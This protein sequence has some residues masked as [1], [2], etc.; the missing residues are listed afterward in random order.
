MA[1]A[2]PT[3]PDIYSAWLEGYSG[4]G[5]P[6]FPI[7]E[8]VR[9]DAVDD[10]GKSTGY[11]QC[12]GLWRLDWVER[13][14]LMNLRIKHFRC[15]R[16]DGHFETVYVEQATRGR[17]QLLDLL[18]EAKDSLEDTAIAL[19]MATVFMST[20][21]GRYSFHGRDW[22]KAAWMLSDG[23][24]AH[25]GYGPRAVWHFSCTNLFPQIEADFVGPAAKE[26]PLALAKAYGAYHRELLREQVPYAKLIGMGGPTQDI[27]DAA[28]AQREAERIARE[29]ILQRKA[30]EQA[31]QE[32]KAQD[33]AQARSTAL[34]RL[35][36]INMPPPVQSNL[37]TM[38]KEDL[39][40]AVW[41]MTTQ[42][43]AGLL[44]CSDVAIHKR[45]RRL[46]IKT[47]PRGFWQRVAAGQIPHPQ[48]IE[49]ETDVR[50]KLS[51]RR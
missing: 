1:E 21:L 41:S 7:F 18:L 23:L 30:L 37:A 33:I 17:S 6:I 20:N 3:W 15:L 8:E 47:P 12:H 25:L 38:S 26:N 48:G 28:N 40:K 4:D 43:L 27:I 46:E 14:E 10:N 19:L 45:C 13:N 51:P 44:G 22:Y 35:S 34:A 42:T 32:R 39:S 29:P 5:E 36:K 31:E 2:I 16:G 11:R 50:R 9:A 24:E 49:P